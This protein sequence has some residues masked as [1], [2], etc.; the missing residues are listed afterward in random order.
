[1]SFRRFGG[2]DR[3]ASYNVMRSH[4]TSTDILLVTNQV[5]EPNSKIVVES[6]L[7]VTTIKGGTGTFNYLD[8][9]NF[10]GD[11]GTFKYLDVKYLTGGTGSFNDLS[12]NTIT[13]STGSFNN[14]AVNNL[15]VNNL[16]GGTGLF[17]NLAVNNLT[18]G[19]GTFNTI[20]ANIFTST[21]DYRV[22]QNVEL[23]NENFTTDLLKPVKYLNT[24]LNKNDIGLIAHEVQEI[25]PE[26][27]NGEKDGLELQSLNYSGLIPILINENRLLKKRIEILE[28]EVEKIK[29]VIK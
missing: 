8:V 14:L 26:L 4:V 10:V 19:T 21:S 15:A 27:V 1:M 2:V 9:K 24:R 18:G 5:G 17:N 28:K 25:Y 11:T 13:G 20:N 23:L 7:D 29:L 16:T 12:V 22:K 6:E 3:A